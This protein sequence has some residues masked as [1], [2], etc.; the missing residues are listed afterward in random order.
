[1]NNSSEQRSRNSV[2]PTSIR[3]SFVRPDPG[4]KGGIAVYDNTHTGSNEMIISAADEEPEIIDPAKQS[5]ASSQHEP[6]FRE[7]P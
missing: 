5:R 1:M 4:N 7:R 3:L 2:V 6:D